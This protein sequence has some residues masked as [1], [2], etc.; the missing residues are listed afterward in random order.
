MTPFSAYLRSLRMAKG[1]T[2]RDVGDRIGYAQT[3]ISDIE[4][5]TNRVSVQVLTPWLDA[6]EAT[7]A[8]RLEAL[9]LA[10]EPP[11]DAAPEA[12]LT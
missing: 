2:Q 8:E 6:L 7:D 12:A 9:R 4:A 11:D 3:S 1:L 10:G 5:G